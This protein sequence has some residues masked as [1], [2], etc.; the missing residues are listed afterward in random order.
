MTDDLFRNNQVLD[1]ILA[2][3]LTSLVERLTPLHIVPVRPGRHV[4]SARFVLP[5]ADRD[6][7]IHPVRQEVVSLGVLVV[8]PAFLVTGVLTVG[9]SPARPERSVF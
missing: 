7:F 2:G 5:D 6:R 1:M 3:A 4:H 9:A 8:P